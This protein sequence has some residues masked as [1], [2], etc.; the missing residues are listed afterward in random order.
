M[1]NRSRVFLGIDDVDSIELCYIFLGY[2]VK[3]T[4]RKNRIRKM[5]DIFLFINLFSFANV[6]LFCEYSTAKTYT[7][8]FLLYYVN[9][10]CKSW[11]LQVS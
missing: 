4:L 3:L 8:L 7:N 10:P 2:N 9:S 1:P 6:R 5:R 11:E